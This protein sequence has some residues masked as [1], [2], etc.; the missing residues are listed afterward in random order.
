MTV[1][2]IGIAAVR[3]YFPIERTRIA[4]AGLTPFGG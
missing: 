1:T 3:A 4:A 2:A